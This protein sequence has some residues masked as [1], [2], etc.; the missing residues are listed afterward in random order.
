MSGGLN[1]VRVLVIDDDK[2][3]AE[4]TAEA[5]ERAGFHCHVA[6]SG[7]E[8]LGRLSAE[9][10]D[11]VITDLRIYDI[12]GFDILKTAKANDPT[13]E[14]VV[15][16][17]FGS[18]PSAVEAM[19]EGAAN[20]LEKP[21]NLETLRTVALSLA[22]KQSLRRSNRELRDLIDQRLGKLGLVGVSSAMRRLHDGL[23][24]IASS[25]A[26]VLVTGESGTGKELV[27]RAIHNLSPRREGPFVA[28]NCAA[29]PE[30]VLESELFGHEK[31]AFTGADR[32]RQGKFEY[33]DG[34]TIFLDEIGEMPLPTQAKFLRVVEERK[35]VR[36]GSNAPV[37]FDARLLAATNRDLEEAVRT[38]R[39][40][41]DLLF[42]LKVVHVE[43]PALR[44]RREDIPLLAEAILDEVQAEHDRPVRALSPE[45]MNWL[46]NHSWPGNVRELRNV[47]ETMVVMARGVRL[48][49]GD[50]PPDLAPPRPGIV[51]AFVSH[52]A[53]LKLEDVERVLIQNTLALT[54]GN[55]ERAAKLLGIGVRTLYRKIKEFDLE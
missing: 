36:I 22:E 17:G 35:V 3:H 49:I 37:P 14:V 4:A 21:V 52:L 51:P 50:L 1:H 23:P 5:L 41:Q 30:G 10:Y 27:A 43:L 32:R 15:I 42:R 45:L 26:T 44:D 25:S 12:D 55:R 38:G 20:Y 48:E 9:R 6:T 28:I 31:G 46:Q 13:V 2:N 8:G 34:G 54:E 53:G 24:Q 19:R 18:V 33:A 29:L 7:R 16:T 40:R 47:L 11:L 39:F